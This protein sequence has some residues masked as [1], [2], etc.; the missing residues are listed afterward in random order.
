MMGGDF[1]NGL[2]TILP[3]SSILPSL[4][5]VLVVAPIVEE[6]LFR[7][8]LYRALAPFGARP[9]ILVSALLFGLF[10]G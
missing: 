5:T 2:S 3:E 1:E 4:I 10:H 7:G 6:F 9:Y 8:I